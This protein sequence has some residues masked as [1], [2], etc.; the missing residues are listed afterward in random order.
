MNVTDYKTVHGQ[1]LKLLSWESAAWL[2]KVPKQKFISFLTN[3][4]YKI[5]VQK[6][7]FVIPHV[8]FAAKSP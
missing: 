7:I 3:T 4:Q 5:S 1:I 6:F 2:S 8:Y